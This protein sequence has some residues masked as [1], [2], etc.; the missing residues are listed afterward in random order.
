[1]LRFVFRNLRARF[2]D[3][4]QEVKALLKSI[5]PGEIA[6]DIGA[7][8][9]SYLVWLSR[10]VRHGQVVAFEP[11]D[12]LARYLRQVV[13]R[14]RLKNVVVEAKAVSDE[15]GR[16]VMYA[17]ND[18]AA[19]PGAMLLE[20][21]CKPELCHP[22]EVERVTL[23]G[24]FAGRKARVAALKI[25]VEGHEPAVFRGAERLLA[26]DSPLLVFECENRHLRPSTVEDVLAWLAE[27]DY[28]GWFID[29]GR[30]VPAS[31]FDAARHQPRE[32]DRFFARPG[33]CN[34]FVMRRAA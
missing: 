13:R 11:Q 14:C 29:R 16:C 18:L 7:N 6:V 32:G 27:R 9:G 20:F 4:T 8:K 23:D 26:E 5:Q 28:G 25:D 1:M 24:Y 15:A 19:A 3:E 12:H 30:L 17:A 2:R 21:H 22:I 34:N 33:Y 31:E 10:Q